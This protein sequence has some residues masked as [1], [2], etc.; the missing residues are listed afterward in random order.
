MAPWSAS[1]SEYDLWWSCPVCAGGLTLRVGYVGGSN[2][3]NKNIG[4]SLESA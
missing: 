2:P 1:P 4:I 3:H